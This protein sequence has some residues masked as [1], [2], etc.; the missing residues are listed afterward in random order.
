[1][2][3]G[4]G[5]IFVAAA[6]VLVPASGSDAVDHGSTAVSRQVTPQGSLV[7]FP[8]PTVGYF[9]TA[10]GVVRQSRDGGRT[11]RRIGS[12]RPLVAL[13]FVSPNYGFALSKRGDFLTTTDQGWTWQKG[14][15]FIP[16]PGQME[17]PAPAMTVDFVDR[18]F[19][20]VAS[21]PRSIFRTRDGGHSWQR[22]DFGCPHGDYLAGIAF[23]DRRAGFAACGG[24]PATIQ[25][26]RGYHFTSDGGT[27]WRYGKSRVEVG[28]VALVASPSA[29]T[30]FVYASRLG[31]FRLGD[32]RTLLAT[33]DADSVLAMSWPTTQFGYA[34][35][36]QGGLM[37]TVDGGLHWRRP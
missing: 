4:L 37:R 9:V 12:L 19:G 32:G 28:H 33:D 17:G 5:A 26:Y 27:H 8:R 2:S 31:I 23:G 25:Q 18:R 6:A 15:R 1:M 22:L 36:F 14:R 10:R 30:R 35:L 24:Q 3:R 13:D 34:L 11:W 16:A 21:G 20:I 7:A 29:R